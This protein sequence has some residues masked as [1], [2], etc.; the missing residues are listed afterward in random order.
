MQNSKL[1]LAALP[2]LFFALPA[3]A[4]TPPTQGEVIRRV[5]PP[6]SNPHDVFRR[7][8]VVRKP[9][10]GEMSAMKDCVCPMKGGGA[11]APQTP[12][13]PGSGN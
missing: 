3:A 1:L 5:A 4:S 9:E 2:A 6:P 7:V 10:P 8:I 13:V 11:T 12:P